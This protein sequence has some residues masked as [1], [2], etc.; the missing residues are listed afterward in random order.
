MNTKLIK[1]YS[2]TLEMDENYIIEKFGTNSNPLFINKETCFVLNRPQLYE[3]KMTNETSFWRRCR[4]S[5]SNIGVPS[6]RNTFEEPNDY[7]AGKIIG[8]YQENFTDY[9]KQCMMHGI[10]Q[11]PIIREQYSKEI[12]LDITEIGMA[13]WK[14]DT[15]FSGS[16]DG[17]IDEN[18]GI[19][20]KAPKYRMYRD[21]VNFINAKSKGYISE[22]ARDYTE[23]NM[24]HIFSSH[25]D[26]MIC[27]AIITNKKKMHYIVL[28]PENSRLYS[29][30]IEIDRDHWDILYKNGCRFYDYWIEPL[31]IENGIKR[32]EPLF[33]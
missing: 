25:Y 19:E 10:L 30:I 11:E 7:F 18:Q 1:Y 31:M 14:Q 2:D 4:L 23:R 27:N 22:I 3:N 13:I 26:Q 28:N 15:R 24:T 29:D 16:L 8:L 33:Y 21:L 32:L 20:I 12:G 5:S 6:N 9:S 17:E